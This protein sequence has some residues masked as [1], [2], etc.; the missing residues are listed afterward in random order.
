VIGGSPPA[1]TSAISGDARPLDERAASLIVALTAILC[2]GFT[3]AAPQLVHAFSEEPQRAVAVLALTLV[4]QMFSVQVYGRGSV[5]VSA[6]GILTAAFLLN[7][8][9]AMSIAIIAALAQ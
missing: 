3:I 5:S 4:L 8:G 2:G 9:T 7:T 1:L 6:I